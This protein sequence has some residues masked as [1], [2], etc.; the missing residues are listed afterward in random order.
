MN[1][2][3]IR[4]ILFFTLLIA[5]LAANAQNA[6][7]GKELFK[8][9]CA[10]CHNVEKD[11]VGPA[12]KDVDKK[13]SAEWIISFVRASQTKIKAGDTA[14]V[15]LFNKYNQAI[16]PD[17]SDLKDDQIKNI[18]EYIKVESKNIGTAK[19]S[20]K[21][22]SEQ[23]PHYMPIKWTNYWFWALFGVLIIIMIWGLQWR[24]KIANWENKD[25]K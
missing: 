9:R 19:S 4:I 22:P 2:Y 25:Q 3:P 24:I 11:L 1:V 13:R 20:A 16:M 12:L 5:A 23:Y 17:H 10:A 15:A 8:T 6:E 21:R 7:A 18:M 14:A